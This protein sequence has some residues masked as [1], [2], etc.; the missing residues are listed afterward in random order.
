MKR[1]FYYRHVP[2]IKCKKEVVYGS[3]ESDIKGVRVRFLSDQLHYLRSNLCKGSVIIFVRP[4]GT[5]SP[6][7]ITAETFLNKLIEV[8]VKKFIRN[9]YFQFK[10]KYH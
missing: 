8:R 10:T 6:N 9:S 7:F 5:I 2:L 3:K 4:S 1:H